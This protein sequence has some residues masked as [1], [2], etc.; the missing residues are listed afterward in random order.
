M[1]KNVLLW[2]LAFVITAL[3][4]VYQRVTGPTYPITG[5]LKLNNNEV[6]YK[7]NRTHGGLSDH[8]VKINVYDENISGDLFFKRYKTSDN[9]QKIP[10]RNNNGELSA[11]LP[12]QPPAGKLQYFVE[13]NSQ[14][15]INKIPNDHPVIIRFKGDV[16]IYVLI[17]HIFAM[18]FGMLLST[19]TGFEYFND[20]K[21]I[22]KLTIWTLAF[23]I[24]GGFILGPIMQKFA[25]GEYWTGFPFGI[26]L[27]DNKTLITILGWIFAFIMYK[28]S[29]NPKLW[30]A[31][32]AILLLIVYLI[33]HSV[34]G[35]ELDYNKLDQQKK[36]IEKIIEKR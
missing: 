11:S 23:L 14:N 2:I 7:L 16:P 5:E 21:N 10:M 6:I 15:K 31:F 35:S 28:K 32:G 4:A 8:E 34:L 17:P 25:F 27:T 26:D 12:H 33:P 36:S 13:F 3:T 19:R 1:K 29:R 18:F 20:G 24:V 22:K 9:W 30:A